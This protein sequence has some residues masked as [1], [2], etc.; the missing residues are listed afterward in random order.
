MNTSEFMQ[1]DYP[2]ALALVKM[3]CLNFLRVAHPDRMNFLPPERS[4]TAPNFYRELTFV[5]IYLR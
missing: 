3:R 4:P 1:R 5:M 2:Q